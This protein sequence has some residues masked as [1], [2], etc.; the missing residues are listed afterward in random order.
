MTPQLIKVF[1][2]HDDRAVIVAEHVGEI[3][4]EQDGYLPYVGLLGG[5]DT[6]LTIDNATGQIL[7]W[8]PIKLDALEASKNDI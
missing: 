5:D 1:L 3:V 8:R 7:N 4:F 2:K 6:E